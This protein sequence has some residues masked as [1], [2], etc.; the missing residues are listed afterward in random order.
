VSDRE[1]NTR[2]AIGNTARR[3]REQLAKA[4]KS[5]SQTD[6]ERRVRD[7]HVRHNER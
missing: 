7:A 1:R 5:I 4:G 3:Y 6:A 2:D